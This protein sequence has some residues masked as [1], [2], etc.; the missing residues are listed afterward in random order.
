[1]QTKQTK[2]GYKFISGKSYG[3]FKKGSENVAQSERGL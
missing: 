2:L 3:Q 1:M